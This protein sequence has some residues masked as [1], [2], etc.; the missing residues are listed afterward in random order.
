[1]PLSG[2][3]NIAISFPEP[4]RAT[5]ANVQ[6]R[7]ELRRL[8]VQND[9]RFAVSYRDFDDYRESNTGFASPAAS[10][11]NGLP[12]DQREQLKQSV[13][14]MVTSGADG[15]IAYSARVNA[16]RGIA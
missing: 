12:T 11:V 16:V 10:A 8:V 1:V 5:A 3:P 15:T 2:G 13:K 9:L 6:R 14:S 4:H 7:S